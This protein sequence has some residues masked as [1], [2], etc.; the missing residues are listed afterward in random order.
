MKPFAI[1][2]S[3]ILFATCSV[4]LSQTDVIR[5]V[6]AYLPGQTARIHVG[7]LSP[8]PNTTANGALISMLSVVIQDRD[9]CCGKDSALGRDL[10]RVNT[11]S[12]EEV[13]DVVKGRHV[14]NDGR[15]VTIETTYLPET[16]VNSWQLIDLIMKGQLAIIEWNHHLYLLKEVSFDE[17]RYSDGT[18]DYSIQRA[19][20]LDPQST[21]KNKEV[22]FDRQKDDWGQIK[23]LLTLVA[24]RD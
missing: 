14:M 3:A 23:G 9:V 22:R 2:M 1:R 12:A 4:C 18:S 8:A 15:W 17:T 13:K 24:K 7:H 16:S 20:L 11:T 6:V 10:E 21:A 5:S 19:V